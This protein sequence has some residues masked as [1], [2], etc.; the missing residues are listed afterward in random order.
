MV[1]KIKQSKALIKKKDFDDHFLA[2]KR[3]KQ[4]MTKAH[5]IEQNVKYLGGSPSLAYNASHSTFVQNINNN[6]SSQAPCL[7][8][9]QSVAVFS[10]KEQKRMPD[11]TQGIPS[12][13]PSIQSNTL[14]LS[15]KSVAAKKISKGGDKVDQIC[16]IP[17]GLI[18]QSTDSEEDVQAEAGN[19]LLPR[20]ATAATQVA[21]NQPK[22][23]RATTELRNLSNLRDSN[24][25]EA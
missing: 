11:K 12:N 7:T 8:G 3:Y 23:Q 14:T 2:H 22:T 24:D 17:A 19:D 25:T 1:Q 10:I 20:I 9:S 15:P 4:H 18:H 6:P 13:L 16:K 21:T 5:Q